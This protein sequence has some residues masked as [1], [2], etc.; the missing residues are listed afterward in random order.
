SGVVKPEI[1]NDVNFEIKSYF[2]KQLR[3]NLF[4]GTEDEDTHEHVRRNRLPAGSI[5]TWDLLER[6]FIWKYFHPFKT[7]MKLEEIR[8]FKQVMDKR[9]YQAW[10]RLQDLL[11]RHLTQE[12]ILKEDGMVVEQVSYIGFFE[13]TVNKFME[14]SVKRQ[15]TID[16]SIRKYKENIELNLKKLDAYVKPTTPP[17]PLPGRLKEHVVEPCITRESVCMIKISKETDEEEPSCVM[18]TNVK[19]KSLQ[20]EDGNRDHLG[21]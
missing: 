1:R 2:M 19:L 7:A 9:L 11:G 20:Q 3:R 17:I 21:L 12:C 15:A 13:E 4:A 10:E 5:T 18:K 6:A 16:E 8:N 14:E